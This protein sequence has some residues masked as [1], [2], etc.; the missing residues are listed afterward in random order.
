MYGGKMSLGEMYGRT[1]VRPIV[2]TAATNA[3]S[4]IWGH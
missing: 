2:D 3:F 4:T 1:T